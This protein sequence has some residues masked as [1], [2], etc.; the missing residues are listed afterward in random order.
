MVTPAVSP[1]DNSSQSCENDVPDW[2]RVEADALLHWALHDKDEAL[3]E[4]VV[5]QE[6]MSPHAVRVIH[7]SGLSETAFSCR[8]G[9]CPTST[10]AAT[11]AST[12]VPD[13]TL[14]SVSLVSPHEVAP[15]TQ[16]TTTIPPDVDAEELPLIG[17]NQDVS[18]MLPPDKDL[19]IIP[20]HSCLPIA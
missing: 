1:L 7:P 11:P 9:L 6:V 4:P 5:I 16:F 19:S 18:V 17:L 13:D 20:V 2:L 15:P 14:L 12:N 3:V 10:G 8:I